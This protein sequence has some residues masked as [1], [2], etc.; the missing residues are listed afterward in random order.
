MK[1]NEPNYI[2]LSAITRIFVY[3]LIFEGEVVYVGK[4][5]TGLAR[6]YAHVNSKLFNQIFV[7]ECEED[8]L[9]KVEAKYILKYNPMYNTNMNK[10]GMYTIRKSVKLINSKLRV[11]MTR[12]KLSKLL[13]ILGIQLVEFN[14]ELYIKPE[15]LDIACNYLITNM[16]VKEKVYDEKFDTWI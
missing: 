14:G 1:F 7:I 9:D 6:V 3:F 13:T 12:P 2:N 4:T 15:D 11:Q 10:N 16:G 8:D 5:T